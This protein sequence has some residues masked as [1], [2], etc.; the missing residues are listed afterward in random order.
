M[1]ANSSNRGLELN[2]YGLLMPGLRGMVSATFLRPEITK[3]TTPLEIGK[4][5]AGVPDKTFSASLDWD[6]PWVAGLALNGRVIYTSGSYLTNANN[7]WQRFSDWTRVRHR[8]ALR[9][10]F[11]RPARHDTRQHRK[12]VRQQILAHDR[13]V[14]DGRVASNLHLIRGIRSL[15]GRGRLSCNGLPSDASNVDS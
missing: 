5:A 12:R 2:A 13:R 7:P 10:C 6:T 8:R 3:T 15:I 1:T 11:Q 14:R 4:D 9:D